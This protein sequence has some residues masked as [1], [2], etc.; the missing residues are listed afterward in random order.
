MP[1]YNEAKSIA[2]VVTQTRQALP[3]ADML[4]VHDGSA[5]TTAQ[6]AAPAGA[7]V[8]SLPFNLGIGGAAQTGYRFAIS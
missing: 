8:L 6:V 3:N 5:D 1:A 4:V 7:T 2:L